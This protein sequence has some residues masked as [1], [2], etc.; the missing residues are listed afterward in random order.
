[1]RP[2]YA[3][4][5]IE[6]V[7]TVA[8]ALRGR[9]MMNQDWR[10]LTFLHW[11]VE[12][13]RVAHLMPPGVRPD[14][15]DGGDVR[16]A[17]PLPDGRRRR[18][19]RA[20]SAVGRVVPRDERAALLGRRDRPPRHRVPQPGHRPLDRGGGA[21]AG[22]GLPYRWARMR[23]A[24]RGDVRTYSASLW[25]PGLHGRSRV[26]VRVGEPRPATPLDEFLSARWGLHVRWWGRTLYVAN[27]HEPWPLHDAEVL[28]LDDGLR[29]SV[30]LGELTG[31]TPDQ[32]AFSPG[33]HTEFCFP[34]DARRPRR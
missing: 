24:A 3:D 17:D 32:V 34:T 20:G 27:E 6:P 28:E 22:F 12:P 18:R 2:A 9:V 14:T 7:S 31:R 23:Y 26:A 1:L 11:A 5:V 4:R 8:P 10:D 30:G 21:R 33:V 29:A 15:L 25:W 19:S 13:E 16:R